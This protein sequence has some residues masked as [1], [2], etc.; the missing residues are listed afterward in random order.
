MEKKSNKKRI[1]LD[2]A[3]TTPLDSHVKKA[4]DAVSFGNPNSLH[5]FGREALKTVDA[6]RA[7]IAKSI[8]A[9][10]NEII[11]T[12]G[13]TEA[14]NLVLRGAV[15]NAQFLFSK[16]GYSS[17]PA[18]EDN[19]RPRHSDSSERN[20]VQNV[21]ESFYQKEIARGY[22]NKKMKIII[23][24]IEHESVFETAKD[25]EREGAEMVIIPVN[26]NGIIDLKKLE[27][28]LDE[29]TVL[30]S[31]MYANNEIGTIQ[32]IAKISEII[33]NFRNSKLQ[34]TNNKQIPNFPPKAGQ[35]RAE[36]LKNRYPL[37][38]TDAV[39]ALQFFNCDVNTLGVDLMTLSAHKIYGPKGVGL[40]YRR[41][42]ND[43]LP[44]TNK[45]QMKNLPNTEKTRISNSY[46]LTPILTG[47]GQ[48]FG[49]RSGTQNVSG[50][51][52]FAKAV[53]FADKNRV[54]ESKRILKLKDELWN[55]IKEIY[56]KAKINGSISE[57]LPNILNVHFPGISSELLLIKF[58]TEGIAV[59]SGSACAART[60]EES[61]VLRAL[62]G[63]PARSRESIRFSLGKYTT[64]NE[65]QRVGKILE[66]I[67]RKIKK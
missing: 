19:L 66:K 12:G 56:P 60:T 13:A 34:N 27:K 46:T 58:D 30:V 53:E 43:K 64:E 65:I 28:E 37:F 41:M 33:R 7:S 25:L 15:H 10:F 21:C 47:G 11:F 44:M 52:G 54:K 50:I 5:S 24:A 40:L 55:L 59:S 16:T 39:Q 14:N 8:D 42:T 6:S 29:R 23:S 48:E 17:I 45:F 22:L 35:P 2:Y 20:Q 1:Y 3:A 49:L 63:S 4:M 51:C 9:E 32:P 57:A 26:K 38:H 62:G 67:F 31:I 18:I 61:H 36:K